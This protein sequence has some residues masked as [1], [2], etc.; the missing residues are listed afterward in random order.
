MPNVFEEPPFFIVGSGRSGTTLVRSLL[1][2]HPR[3]AVPPET[4]FMARVERDRAQDGDAPAD[5]DA[6]WHD[7]VRWSRFRDLGVDPSDVR[8]RIERAGRRDFKTVFAAM[9]R[10]YADRFG[11]P[12]AGEKTPSHYRHVDRLF[13]WFPGVRIVVVQRDPRAVVASQLRSPWVVEQQVP[14][15]RLQPLVRRLRLFHVAE[16]AALWMEAYD[17]HLARADRDP[18]FHVVAYERLVA[19]AATELGRLCEFLGEAYEPAMLHERNGT[20]DALV[21]K[22]A[23]P[24]WRSWV[25]EHHSRASGAISADGRETWR[26]ELSEREIALIEGLCGPRMAKLGYQPEAGR[27]NGGARLANTLLAAEGGEARLRRW[28]GRRLR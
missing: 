27:H 14:T 21:A 5:F 10:A 12:R 22:H 18:R 26:S 28:L 6:F 24:T 23:P 9:L 4:H 3:L 7:L 15:R 8:Q 20:R 2:A 25:D 1:D 13:A 17:R 19:D 11:K 16:H